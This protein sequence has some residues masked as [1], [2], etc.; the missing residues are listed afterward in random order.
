ML[1]KVLGGHAMNFSSLM[2]AAAFSVALLSASCAKREDHSVDKAV[3]S[4]KQA[5]RDTG[6]AIKET[7][8]DIKNDAQEAGRDIKSDVKETAADVKRAAQ[9]PK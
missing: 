8:R 4:T 9:D 2:I 5:A 3:E 6:E 1:A 7:G